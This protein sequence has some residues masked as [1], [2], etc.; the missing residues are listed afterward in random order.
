MFSK[1]KKLLFL[2]AAGSCTLLLSACYGVMVEPV[3]IYKK[4]FNTKDPSGSPIP[5]LRVRYYKNGYLDKELMTDTNGTTFVGVYSDDIQAT[6]QFV[7]DDIDGTNNL[8]SFQSF[9]TNLN[10][11]GD[12]TVDITMQTN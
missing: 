7:I 3:F 2:L 12:E 9:T 1:L 8:G 11:A 5:G 4:N 10:K 6:N